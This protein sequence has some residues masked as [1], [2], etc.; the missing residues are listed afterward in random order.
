[1]LKP[2]AMSMTV[3]FV[4]KRVFI[5]DVRSNLTP[6]LSRAAK[7]RRKH[8]AQIWRLTGVAL[9]GLPESLLERVQEGN[10][11]DYIRAVII[12]AKAS[13]VRQ[14]QA[15]FSASVSPRGHSLLARLGQS[16]TAQEFSRHC[17][18]QDADHDRGDIFPVRVKASEGN[19]ERRRRRRRV[20]ST[21]EQMK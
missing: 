11:R 8:N 1:M 9:I 20:V 13:S 4:L 6:E 5:L 18:D 14:A 3:Q 2:E 12:P 16:Q 15:E 7:M 10:L 19:Q 21:Q 17:D